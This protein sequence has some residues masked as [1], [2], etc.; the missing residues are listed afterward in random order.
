MNHLNRTPTPFQR[1]RSKSRQRRPTQKFGRGEGT[2]AGR[3]AVTD[4]LPNRRGH[5]YERSKGLSRGYT[6]SENCYSCGKPGHYARVC[7]NKDS[8]A[9]GSKE[10]SNLSV[11][12][13]QIKNLNKA[14]TVGI[15]IRKLNGKEIGM[16]EVLLDTGADTRIAD[17]MFIQKI[18]FHKKYS[19]K[20][21]GNRIKGTTQNYFKQL[22]S[23]TWKSECGGNLMEDSYYY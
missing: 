7:P 2:V 5:N 22:G 1:G 10:G 17:E 4:G 12:V 13:A 19:K 3:P 16:P 15:E 18:V 20:T 9:N 6:S 23:I 21:W 14:P 8:G 11:H